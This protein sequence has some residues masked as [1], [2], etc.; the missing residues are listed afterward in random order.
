[1]VRIFRRIIFF[2]L[3]VSDVIYLT[4]LYQLHAV[5]RDDEYVN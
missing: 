2:L 5:G 4:M 1:M 3:I